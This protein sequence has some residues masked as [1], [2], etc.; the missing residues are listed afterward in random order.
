MFIG[1]DDNLN[2]IIDVSLIHIDDL[3][4]KKVS[5]V[6]CLGTKIDERLTWDENTCM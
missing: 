6:K 5:S 2:R 4:M 1:S 3:A